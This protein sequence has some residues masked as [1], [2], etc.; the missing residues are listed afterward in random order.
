MTLNN[1]FTF[2][3]AIIVSKFFV[4]LF[5]RLFWVWW[6]YICCNRYLNKH[7]TQSII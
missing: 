7:K 1:C 2:E 5:V 3:I 6:I 4:V